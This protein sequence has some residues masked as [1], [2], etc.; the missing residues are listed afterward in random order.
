MKVFKKSYIIIGEPF[1]FSEYYD[2]KFTEEISQKCTEK[3]AKIMY[4]LQQEVFAYVETKKKNKG[5]KR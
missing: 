1:D 3:L 4:D 5:K 2:V